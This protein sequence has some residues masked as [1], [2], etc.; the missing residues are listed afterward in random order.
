MQGTIMAGAQ[1]AGFD[2]H[3]GTLMHTVVRSLQAAA[4]AADVRKGECPC[5]R[6]DNMRGSYEVLQG[7]SMPCLGSDHLCFRQACQPSRSRNPC[8]ALHLALS[9]SQD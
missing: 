5:Q 3:A 6:S 7:F 9:L 8:Q 1:H 2:G 4:V